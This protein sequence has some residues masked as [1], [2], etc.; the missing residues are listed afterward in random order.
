MKAKFQNRLNLKEISELRARCNSIRR[1]TDLEYLNFKLIRP[2]DGVQ[3]P[4]NETEADLFVKDRIRIL[5]STN[6]SQALDMIE[7]ILFTDE[8][9]K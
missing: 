7:T 2:T 4:K 8:V 1:S 9:L 5:F 6:I 3:Y